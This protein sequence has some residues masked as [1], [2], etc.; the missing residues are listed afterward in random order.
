LNKKKRIVE[1]MIS[2][3]TDVANKLTLRQSAIRTGN[4]CILKF[5]LEGK[6]PERIEPP[7][8][9][10]QFTDEEELMKLIIDS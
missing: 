7:T 8:K 4:S 9:T 1:G 10:D 3:V 5:S 6:A 2:P